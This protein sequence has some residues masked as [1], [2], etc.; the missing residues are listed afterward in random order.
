MLLL[1]ENVP[2]L[3]FNLLFHDDLGAK[4]IAKVYTFS[5]GCENL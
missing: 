2:F 5:K 4:C 1:G 3:L